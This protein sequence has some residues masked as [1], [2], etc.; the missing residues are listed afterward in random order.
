MITKMATASLSSHDSHVP[1]IG[2]G[3][4]PM[5]R[6]SLVSLFQRFLYLHC[7]IILFHGVGPARRQKQEKKNNRVTHPDVK[8]KILLVSSTRI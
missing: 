6:S 2:P 1:M 4:G 5:G 3:A 8:S 7:K